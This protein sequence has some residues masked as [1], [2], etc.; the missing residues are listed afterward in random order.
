MHG[1]KR[2]RKGAIWQR[3]HGAATDKSW[4][5]WSIRCQR[6]ARFARKLRSRNYSDNG[7]C[8]S[9]Q[10]VARAPIERRANLEWQGECRKALGTLPQQNDLRK[11]PHQQWYLCPQPLVIQPH[12]PYWSFRPASTCAGKQKIA[13]CGIKAAHQRRTRVRLRDQLDCGARCLAPLS[14]VA[15][16][17]EELTSSCHLSALIHP[18]T[19]RLVHSPRRSHSVRLCPAQNPPL[20]LRGTRQ[21]L[22]RNPLALATYA[23][24]E[25]RRRAAQAFHG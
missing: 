7:Y 24:G 12:F 14:A 13:W 1:A 16:P 19:S 21:R 6:R 11:S 15:A 8:L 4:T 22:T 18:G 5:G 9:A 23:I 2:K 17:G 25:R 10:G 3:D 20:I